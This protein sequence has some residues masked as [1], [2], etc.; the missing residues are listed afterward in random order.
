MEN[1]K[2]EWLVRYLV[3]GGFNVTNPTELQKKI[4]GMTADQIIKAM[5]RARVL[6]EQLNSTP[7]GRELV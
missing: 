7:L 5:E 6:Q 4:S 1:T 3:D 2:Q